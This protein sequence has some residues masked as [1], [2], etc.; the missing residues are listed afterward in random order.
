MPRS[1]EP[2]ASAVDQVAEIIEI[3]GADGTLQYVNGSFERITGYSREE[4]LGRTPA[5]LLRSNI[6]PIEFY[7]DLW[8]Q[9][10]SG[11]PWSGRIVS[12]ARSGRL[13]HQD[14]TVSP[15]LDEFGQVSHLV[16]VKRDVTARLD[17]EARVRDSERLVAVGNL[18]AGVAHEVSNPLTYLLANLEVAHTA[19]A[20]HP[21]EPS[22][23]S[24]AIQDALEGA[25]RIAKVIGDL[26]SF[27]LVP[28]EPPGPVSLDE[29][30]DECREMLAHE[31]NQRARLT[32]DIGS[33][34]VSGTRKDLGQV[35]LPLL[36]W[37]VQSIPPGSRDRH[38]IGVREV[39]A[40]R[41]RVVIELWHD[42]QSFAPEDLAH[43]FDPYSQ[44]DE[45][46]MPTLGL[47]I[48]NQ[49]A[50][51]H[52]DGITVEP[53]TEGGVSFRVSLRRWTPENDSDSSSLSRPKKP[54]GRR[55]AR[56][57]AIDDEPLIL[58]V[59][60]TALS[61]HDLVTCTNGYEALRLVQI[62]DFDVIFCDL[63][64][65]ELTGMDVYQEIRRLRPGLEDR[66]VLV[67]GGSVLPEVRAFLAA[68]PNHRIH[69]PFRLDDFRRHVEERVRR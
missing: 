41:R 11:K 36:S 47:A 27:V 63:M 6:H 28:Q 30:L 61:E 39:A 26:R 49:L 14:A 12:R 34:E 68:V 42:G 24:A 10:M 60:R 65:P 64:M 67:T 35:F 52:G 20:A 38:T 18:A 23:L 53:R 62:H 3:C 8:R 43:L 54:R 59:L 51:R 1:L 50:A 22:L 45:Q 25:R 31:L 16:A 15:V 55:R 17:L 56:L 69:K 21:T 40:S 66:I 46:G 37:A 44:T 7:E 5:S 57:L 2:L 19:V 4:A 9:V 33:A 32:L 13:I 29:V 58:D 48:A